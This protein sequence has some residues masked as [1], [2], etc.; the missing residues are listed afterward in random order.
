MRNRC[1][2]PPKILV[3]PNQKNNNNNPQKTNKQKIINPDRIQVTCGPVI[4]LNFTFDL[5]GG[6]SVT[7]RNDIFGDLFHNLYINVMCTSSLVT[8]L[9]P[10]YK[11][12]DRLP[13]TKCLLG[14]C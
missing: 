14:S 5:T 9:P 3:P 8:T 12:L 11:V 7:S 10:T 6:Y 13:K 2:T 1:T 4:R